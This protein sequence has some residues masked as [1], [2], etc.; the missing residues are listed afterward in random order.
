MESDRGG[1]GHRP[2]PQACGKNEKFMRKKFVFRKC[3]PPRQGGG[4]GFIVSPVFSFQICLCIACGGMLALKHTHRPAVKPISH[5]EEVVSIRHR[6]DEAYIVEQIGHR[7]HSI[8]K[9]A[10]AARGSKN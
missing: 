5:L 9:A 3:D 10:N 7:I 8:C 2:P 4:L 6:Y 1:E